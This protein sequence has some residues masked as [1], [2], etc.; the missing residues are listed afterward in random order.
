MT[1]GAALHDTDHLRTGLFAATSR[2]MNPRHAAALA[3]AYIIGWAFLLAT[4]IGL[5]GGDRYV[6]FGMIQQQRNQFISV[7]CLLWL[8]FTIPCIPIGII[9]LVPPGRLK[10][11][12]EVINRK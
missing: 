12:V 3:C 5:T 1:R 6:P 4:V 10:F 11:L 9:V 8:C 7:V 2:S